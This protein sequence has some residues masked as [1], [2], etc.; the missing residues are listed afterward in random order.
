MVFNVL[1]KHG[2]SWGTFEHFEEALVQMRGVGA[3]SSVVRVSDNAIL[4]WMTK[5]A[6]SEDMGWYGRAKRRAA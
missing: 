4:A 5:A 1:D 3:G 6:R 2:H